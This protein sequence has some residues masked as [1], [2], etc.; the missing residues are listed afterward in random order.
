MAAGLNAVF[1]VAIC[2][3]YVVFL[4]SYFI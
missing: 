3:V 2:R 4:K 1:N